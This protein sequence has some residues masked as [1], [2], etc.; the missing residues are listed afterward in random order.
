MAEVD[1][2]RV[3]ADSQSGRWPSVAEAPEVS[4]RAISLLDQCSEGDES[5]ED[6]AVIGLEA[7]QSI[8][9]SLLD[10][11]GVGAA[12]RRER[13][14][15][16]GTILAVT[17]SSDLVLKARCLSATAHSQRYRDTFSFAWCR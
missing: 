11:P 14:D 10:L 6:A 15:A 9:C 4:G 13:E 17:F 8:C 3:S 12:Q 1:Q 5:S 16:A 2:L 7:L